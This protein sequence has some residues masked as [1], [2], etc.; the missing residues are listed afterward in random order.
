[1]NDALI[2]RVEQSAGTGQCEARDNRIKV[3]G[4]QKLESKMQ[5]ICLISWKHIRRVD[6]QAQSKSVFA[7]VGVQCYC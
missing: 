5:S 2:G 6:V 7:L 4:L 1:M 3:D